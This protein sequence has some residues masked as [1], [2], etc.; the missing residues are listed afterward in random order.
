[1]NTPSQP[2]PHP[3]EAPP[4]ALPDLDLFR[5]TIRKTDLQVLLGLFARLRAHTPLPP[6]PPWPADYIQPPPP[7]AAILSDLS[8][9]A[10]TTGDAGL[11]PAT[12]RALFSA[13][14]A[15]ADVATMIADAKRTLHPA[16]YAS[17]LAPPDPDRLMALLT[18]APAEERVLRRVA[19]H[20]RAHCPTLPPALVDHLWRTHIIPWTK[21]VELHHL[22][23]P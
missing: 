11:P 6:P 13:L 3:R 14:H 4:S 18:D 22:L 12:Y 8:A 21:Q 5:E 7:L 17:A 23:H 1:M 19:D 20:A 9:G 16:D 10:P 15:R 2:H